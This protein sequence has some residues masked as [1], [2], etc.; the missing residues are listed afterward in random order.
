MPVVVMLACCATR[1]RCRQ[2]S[3]PCLLDHLCADCFLPL[4]ADQKG[5]I[6]RGISGCGRRGHTKRASKE[7]AELLGTS[8]V[9]TACAAAAARG[10]LSEAIPRQTT[11]LD[12]SRTSISLWSAK[13][14]L[15]QQTGQLR[16]PGGRNI[17]REPRRQT[18][19]GLYEVITTTC[20]RF[21][22][23]L[24]RL[25]CKKVVLQEATR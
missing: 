15:E 11:K 3:S 18:K 4:L 12:H 24:E 7:G 22:D 13:V 17:G 23:K 8:P 10:T 20:V 21:P 9:K 25:I 14:R 16:R 2:S 6:K 1:L 19:N 5:G